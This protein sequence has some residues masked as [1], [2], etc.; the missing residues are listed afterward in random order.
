M[1]GGVNFID[2]KGRYASSIISHVW[3]LHY[4]PTLYPWPFSVTISSLSNNF[5]NV[6]IYTSSLLSSPHSASDHRTLSSRS[7]LV[8]I[9]PRYAKRICMMRSCVAER[10]ICSPSR[11]TS[12]RVKSNVKFLHWIRSCNAFLCVTA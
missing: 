9:A 2:H 12:P 8:T 10:W 4:T 11:M 7:L 1:E 3:R 5:L 6:E